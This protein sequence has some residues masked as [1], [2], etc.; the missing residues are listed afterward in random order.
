MVGKCFGISLK[1]KNAILDSIK[2]VDLYCF[3]EDAAFR[4]IHNRADAVYFDAL[5]QRIENEHCHFLFRDCH[6]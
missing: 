5:I 4:L 2:K 6:F 1:F 3:I